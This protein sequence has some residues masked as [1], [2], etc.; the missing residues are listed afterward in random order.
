M[1]RRFEQ[2]QQDCVFTVLSLLPTLGDQLLHELNVELITAKLQQTRSQRPTPLP[3]PDTSMILPPKP[4]E[5]TNG[6]H[7]GANGEIK[8]NVP[9]GEDQEQPKEDTDKSEEAN[10]EETS[11]ATEEDTAEAPKEETNGA[12]VNGHVEKTEDSEKAAESTE[13]TTHVSGPLPSTPE[14]K[15]QEESPSTELE[16]TQL[17]KAAQTVVRDEAAVAIDRRTKLELWNELKVMS[18]LTFLCPLTNC[19]PYVDDS[20]DLMLTG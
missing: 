15:V 7:H 10:T 18:K 20:T 4:S 9:E 2:N 12:Q 1:K 14:I 5:G 6:E 8:E 11:S 3:T 13:E 19:F 16:K 17:H